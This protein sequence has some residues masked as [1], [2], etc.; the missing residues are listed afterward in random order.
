MQF[1]TPVSQTGFQGEINLS[2]YPIKTLR[3]PCTTSGLGEA[4]GSEHGGHLRKTL[5]QQSQ[6]EAPNPENRTG[7]RTKRRTTPRYKLNP[8]IL[9]SFALTIVAETRDD[10]GRKR[11]SGKDR[12]ELVEK[13]TIST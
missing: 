3:V 12:R 13:R 8:Y 2:V 10:N 9:R 5:P 4:L 11:L 1:H 6:I 7:L